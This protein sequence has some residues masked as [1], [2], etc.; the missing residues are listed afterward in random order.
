MGTAALTT[1][2]MNEQALRQVAGFI[3]EALKSPTDES[4]LA[5]VNQAVVEMLKSYPVPADA[6]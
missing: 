4:H 1:R 2:G 6:K 3:I 5:K